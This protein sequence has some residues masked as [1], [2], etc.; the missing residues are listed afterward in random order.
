MSRVLI[1]DD[2]E[3]SCASLS[4]LCRSWGHEVWSALNGHEA[5]GL[6]AAFDP[7]VVILDLALPSHDGWAVARQMRAQAGNRVYIIALSGWTRPS[8]KA[9][10]LLAGADDFFLKPANLDVLRHLLDV[11]PARIASR[12][13]MH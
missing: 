13:R 5:L 6:H 9:R 8:D 3:D 12:T 10:A 11:A 7:D 2:D 1:V 4:E